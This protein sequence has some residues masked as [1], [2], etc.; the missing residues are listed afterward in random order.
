MR[1]SWLRQTWIPISI[2]VLAGCSGGASS[3][4]GERSAADT[5]A[6]E[7]QPIAAKLGQGWDKPAENMKA[8]CV[9]SNTVHVGQR[10]AVISMDE[11]VD[12]S[13][14]SSE[15]GFDIKAKGHYMIADASTAAKLQQSMKQDDYSEVFVFKA[16]YNLGSDSLDENTLKNTVVGDGAQQQNRWQDACGDE[17]VYQIKNGARFYFVERIDFVS[18]EEKAK[19]DAA[20]NLSF[21]AGIAS[22]S[23]DAALNTVGQQFAKSARVRIEAYQ[24]GG[25]PSALG[26]VLNGVAGGQNNQP[27]QAVA[28]CDITDLAACRQ[29][30][31]NAVAYTDPNNPHG[32]YAQLQNPQYAANPIAYVTQPWSNFNR[33]TT[34]K[35]LTQEIITARTELQTK[36]DG[37]IK[38]KVRIDR[39]LDKLTGFQ[40][41]PDQQTELTTWQ[42][43]LT[44]DLGLVNQAVLACYD[45]LQFTTGGQPL[46][47]AITACQKAV[48]AVPSDQPPASLLTAA[49]HYEIDYHWKQLG[50]VSSVVGDYWRMPLCWFNPATKKYTC[51][52][53][54]IVSPEAAGPAQV[55][56][57]QQFNNGRIYWSPDTDAFEMHGEIL[58][59]YVALGGPEANATV[60]LG[61]PITDEMGTPDGVGRFNRLQNGMIYFTP[62]TG[63][64]EIHGDIGQKWQNMGYERGFLG[65]P[66]TDETGAPD[67]HGRFNHFQGGSIYW[68]LQT[69][70]HAIGGE[71]R[72]TWANEGWERSVYGYPVSDEIWEAGGDWRHQDFQGGMIYWNNTLMLQ[73]QAHIF[74]LNGA[75]GGKFREL[76][77][78]GTSVL[79]FP[80][81]NQVPTPVRFDGVTGAFQPFQYGAIY[82]TQRFG[83]HEVGGAIYQ[84]WAAFG[85]EK[86][87]TLFWVSDATLGYPSSDELDITNFRNQKGR[88]EYFEG[89][90]IYWSPNTGAHVIAGDFSN[91]WHAAGGAQGM[92]GFP[93]NDPSWHTPTIGHNYY[94]QEFEDGYIKYFPGPHTVELHCPSDGN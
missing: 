77:D 11:T 17:V 18:R 26:G 22:G 34:P 13:S 70:P 52:P 51:T 45:K 29:I 63:A 46:A 23:I 44:D 32:L 12:S 6:P 89:G 25:D 86:G 2:A 9:S 43:R 60:Q 72:D 62:S 75:I 84:E 33:N 4:V 8:Q 90:E 10:D 15:L 64:H 87:K 92:C 61:F 53:G 48:D 19:F 73:G 3:T 79:G 30:R 93:A 56:L 21:S 5:I 14:V 59:K 88:M 80:T 58:K 38:W 36:F 31:A 24:F 35:I 76:R 40:I 28:S 50:G 27:G 68:T 74:E 49:G 16:D 65:Y 83:A 42:T 91:A 94:R 85:W 67:G 69:G 1:R 41:P 55:G 81:G 82:W 57:M 78:N 66:V 20:A 71:I 47:T 37:L 54:P 7:T 39:L